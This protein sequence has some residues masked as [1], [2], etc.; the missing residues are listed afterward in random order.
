LYVRLRDKARREGW[1]RKLRY[2]LY[3]RKL[4]YLL[5]EGGIT[6]N[7]AKIFRGLKGVLL[8]GKPADDGKS[9]NPYM[10]ALQ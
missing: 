7:D 5:Y 2:L 8:Q 1:L 3:V 10:A 4:R 6:E 9:H